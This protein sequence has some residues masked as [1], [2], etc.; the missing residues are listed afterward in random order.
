MNNGWPSTPVSA[1]A[2]LLADDR[3]VIEPTVTS[4]PT[5]TL[6]T[7]F[8]C[9]SF[10][11]CS[12]GLVVRIRRSHRRGRGSIPCL[13]ATGQ[14]PCADA[15]A[16]LREIALIDSGA[17][18]KKGGHSSKHS[19]TQI[20]ADWPDLYVYRVGNADPTYNSLSLAEF[21]AGYLSIMEEVTPLLPSNARL[22]RHLTYL[23]QLMEDSFLADWEVVKMA[24]K[25]VLLSIEHKRIDWDNAAL[26]LDTKR[27]ALARIQQS[28][29]A[30]RPTQPLST[31]GAGR[32]S[33]PTSVCNDYQTLACSHATDHDSDGRTLWH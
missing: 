24:L 10:G 19:V 20:E 13:G 16:I 6:S 26:V 23:R 9:R 18:R 1:I 29:L 30:G 27:V 33:V 31:S 21:V 14:L 17:R 15:A 28:A 7:Q 2:R 11:T 25:Q 4:L 12:S 5:W 32:G 22:L 3:L 8:P